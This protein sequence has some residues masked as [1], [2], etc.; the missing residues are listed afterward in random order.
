MEDLKRD[1]AGGR[2]GKLWV[3][4]KEDGF[5]RLQVPKGKKKNLSQGKS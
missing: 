4:N 1:D 2:E 3:A 5:E